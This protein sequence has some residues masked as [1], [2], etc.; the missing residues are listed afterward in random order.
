[1]INDEVLSYLYSSEM[2]K[3]LAEEEQRVFL[4]SYAK[5]EQ[6]LQIMNIAL[7]F[8]AEISEVE[9]LVPTL[10][11][12]NEIMKKNSKTVRKNTLKDL[13]VMEDN[14]YF[15]PFHKKK[16]LAAPLIIALDC[17]VYMNE[18]ESQAKGLI[19][20]FLNVCAE[21][22][23][24]CIV[25]PFAETTDRPIV[26]THGEL[27]V[28]SMNKFLQRSTRN[29]AKL[30]PVLK[31]ALSIINLYKVKQDAELMIVTTNYFDDFIEAKSSN[32]VQQL[33]SKHVELSVIAMDAQQFNEE[34]LDF[35]DKVFFADAEV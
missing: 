4:Q 7:T 29:R 31:V 9:A 32:Y 19:V 6:F 26:F 8:Q 5:D 33:K 23:R 12:S 30:L 10:F 28:A 25:L 24:D 13:V 14:V 22:K 17:S 16:D 20:P 1:M 15:V 2:F 18:F 27:Q 34:P 3:Y 35:I 11:D 21:Q